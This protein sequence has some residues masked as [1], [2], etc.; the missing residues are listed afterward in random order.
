MLLPEE[1]LRRE[2]TAA[3]RPHEH[4]ERY[5]QPLQRLRQGGLLVGRSQSLLLRVG[6]PEPHRDQGQ[7]HHLGGERFRAR[8]GVFRPRVLVDAA[9]RHVRDG[10][11]DGVDDADHGNVPPLREP[12]HVDELLRLAGLRHDDQ[13]RFRRVAVDAKIAFLGAVGVHRRDVRECPRVP[14]EPGAVV[15]GVDTAPAADYD[16]ILD[17]LEFV[18]LVHQATEDGGIH[19]EAS[20]EAQ[21]PTDGL[22]LLHHSGRAR[23]ARMT[24]GMERVSERRGIRGAK[25]GKATDMVGST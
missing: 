6:L 5:R 13:T 22:R 25:C 12:D 17:I 10:A 20:A 21:C 14:Q 18:V 8:H 9:L 24:D 23:K 7:A 16:E 3:L 4:A 19:E 1:F 15:R 11:T 2:L